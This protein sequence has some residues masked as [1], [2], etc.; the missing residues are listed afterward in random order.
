MKQQTYVCNEAPILRLFFQLSA[1]NHGRSTD[2][3]NISRL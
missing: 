1:E 3:N 2:G